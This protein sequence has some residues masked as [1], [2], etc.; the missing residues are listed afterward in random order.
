MILVGNPAAI[1]TIVRQG[2]DS[3][4]GNFTEIVYEGTKAAIEGIRVAAFAGALTGTAEDVGAYARLTARYGQAGGDPSS[5]T[6]VLEYRLEHNRIEKGIENHSLFETLTK[7]EIKEVDTY[8]ET[9]EGDPDTFSDLQAL[10]AEFRIRDVKEWTVYQPHLIVSYT[11]PFGYPFVVNYANIGKVFTTAGLEAFLGIDFP[12]DLPTYDIPGFGNV[13][14]LKHAPEVTVV[15]RQRSSLIYEFEYARW[16]EDL[17][18][19]AT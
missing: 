13:G 11:A 19:L 14:W 12:Y 17:Y 1:T 8:V 5:E 3:Q 10:M 4:L 16:I 9:G 2:W 7:E 15:A 18:P 6:P